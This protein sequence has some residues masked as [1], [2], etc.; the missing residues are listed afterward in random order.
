[1]IKN[2]LILLVFFYSSFAFTQH[3]FLNETKLSKEDLESKKCVSDP[4][5]AAEVLYRSYHYRIDYNGS[6][7]TEV[8]DRVKIYNKDN[9]SR[10]LYHEI[11][12]YDNGKGSREVLSSLKAYTY[13]LENGKISETKVANDSKFKSKENKQYT[14]TKFAFPNVKDG[15]VVEFRYNVVTPFLW[16]TPRI[17]IEDQVP[18][19]YVE[20]VFDSPKPLGYN[21][22]F[23]GD[24]APTHRDV[25]E[26]LIYGGDYQVYRFAYENVPSYKDEDFV[27]NNNN[28][29]TSFRAELNSTFIGNEFKSYATSWNDVGG[30]LNKHEDFGEQLKKQNAV[31]DV[32]PKEIT[33]ILNQNERAK[34]ILSFVQKNYTFNK[35]YD[36]VTD[37]GI[38][39]LLNTK[40]GNAAEIN[41]LLTMLLRNANINANPVVM[42][43]INRGSLLSY[44][45]SL[46]QLNFVV[47]AYEDQGKLVL[48]DATKKRTKLNMIDPQALNNNGILVKDNQ[49]VEL[50]ITYPDVSETF[51]TVDATMSPEGTFQG[52]FADRDTN[53]YSVMVEEEY[54]SNRQDFEKQY[55]D[56]YTFPFNNLKSGNVDNDFETSFDFDADSFVDVIGNKMVFNPLLFLYTKNHSFNQSQTRK[57]PL[58]FR[59]KSAKI[60]T[61]TITIP[62]GY[63]FSD[64][65]KSKK[66]RTDDSAIQYSYVVKQE[67]N[68][69]TVTTTVNH[70]E[71]NF[72]KEYYTAFT[73]IYDN[74][75]KLEGQVVT[76]VKQ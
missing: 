13:N 52:H 14:I 39:N 32:L 16:S 8:I 18:V 42:S 50:N 33:S 67:G 69:L 24:L 2:V 53:L 26:K 74:I 66:F 70:N 12:L 46:E 49:A 41:L 58:E 30:I 22:N 6:M 3:K 1:M 27:L 29:R 15:S 23:K 17:Y 54:S 61:V 48:L 63:V 9:A 5:A 19:R 73:Q 31:K 38:R 28:F 56:R 65:P 64:V 44:S 45:P 47:A 57:G 71:V 21:I 60:K 35:D 68:S 34:A 36:V 4:E 55:K 43:T 72:P 51:L 75:T 76:V 7:Y 20:Y 11:Q 10:Y 62:E 37:K 40:I 59:T 25:S